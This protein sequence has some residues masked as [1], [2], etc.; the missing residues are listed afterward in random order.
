MSEFDLSFVV[1]SFNTQDL[2]QACLQS[3]SNHC[4]K[5][6]YEVIVV[7]NLSTDNSTGMAAS[8]FP[9]NPAHGQYRSPRLHTG[10]QPGLRERDRALCANL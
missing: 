2:T 8:E 4:L 5:M 1:V 9:G 10:Q 6:N 3:V 7:D